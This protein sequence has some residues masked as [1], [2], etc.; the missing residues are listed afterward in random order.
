[1][2]EHLSTFDNV[3]LPL[4][5]RNVAE[6]DVRQHV[7][8]LL[9]WVGLADQ[10]DAPTPTLS[11]GQQQRAAIARAVIRPSILVADKRRT[12]FEDAMAVRLMYLFENSTVSARPC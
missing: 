8:E 5:V 7:G 10:I 1:L 4:R 9:Q 3:A 12:A 2:I 11:G 6:R